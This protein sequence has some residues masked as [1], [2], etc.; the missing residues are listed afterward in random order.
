MKEEN[1]QHEVPE[2]DLDLEDDSVEEVPVSAGPPDGPRAIDL[3]DVAI[4]AVLPILP[5]RDAVAFPGTIMPLA[6][7]REKSKRL[8][9]MALAGDRL[10]CAVAQRVPEKDDPGIDD[11]HRVGTACMILKMYKLPDGTETIVVH[12][13][14]RVGIEDLTSTEPYLEARV[15]P[16]YDPEE[17]STELE[18]LMHNARHAAH[19]I[20]EL[21]P[22]VPDEARIVLDNL[23]TPGGL[24]DF[25]GANLSLS[26]VHKQEVLETLDVPSRLRKVHAAMEGQLDVLELSKKIQS[27]VRSQLDKAQREHYLR[28]QLK[29]IQHELGQE[30]GSSSEITRLREKVQAARMSKPALA[31]AER[32]IE[33]MTKIHPASPEYGVALD[34]V[35]WLCALPW[36]A[37]TK[38][39]LD[40]DRA[41]AILN[42]DHYGLAKVKPRILEFLAVRKL[43]PD[44]RGPILCFAGPPGVGKTSLGKSIA[45]ALGRKFIRM[46]LGGMRDEA[47]IR[48][49]R[50]TYI[51]AMPGRILQE[52]RKAESNNPVFML[53]EV[54]KI[55]SD[56]RGDPASALLE[57][58]DP[59]Q[60]NTFTDHYLDVP[61]DLSN[62]L[63]IATANYMDPI[64]QPLLDRME[65]IHISGYTHRE[66]LEIA[67]QYLV[68]RELEENGLKPDQ[69]VFDEAALNCL[70]TGYT[71]EA[72][73][74]NLD[75]QIAAVCR[76]RA[77]AVVRGEKGSARVTPE[78]IEADLGPPLLEPAMAAAASL[79]GVAVG[80]AY[81]PIGGDILFI[82]A[83]K[84]PGNGNLNLTGQ[85]GGVMRESAQAA[86]SIVRSRAASLGI[87]PADVLRHDYHVHVPAG[88][89]PKDGPSAG[90]AILAALVSL[91]KDRCVDRYTGITGEITLR[92]R[93]M[94][95]GGIRAKV[96]AAH[97]AGLKRVILPEGNQRDLREVPQD[98][99]E[100]LKFAF[101]QTTDD[102]LRHAFADCAGRSKPRSAI[103]RSNGAKRKATTQARG[104]KPTARRKKARRQPR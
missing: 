32:E 33:R 82:E 6:V 29:A 93:V 99:R 14:V 70:I 7:S 8:L 37:H 19:R 86:F 61:F 50:R 101:A 21:S 17:L 72:G 48:G 95:V 97:R 27:Q 102:V 76:A 79:P 81:T 3:R 13:I 94:P 59:A 49:H 66:K 26:L 60:N 77:A 87:D 91:L 5:L 4:P 68:P 83:T 44:G 1:S 46:S 84:M 35:N 42:E 52:I 31:E 73:V 58:L 98:I 55:G 85:L 65:V 20:L 47:E 103:R 12:G 69:A 2:T 11:L 80:L 74:R 53:D 67:R 18:A 43:K 96:L 15:H 51:G 57:V 71:R 16:R 89:I 9:D 78:S 100:Q 88:A 54:D 63:F 28:E 39:R 30:S 23:R 10:I 62:V 40:V 38:D 104:A 24:A 92:G 34:Y 90:S 64:P 56:F 22:N 41:E 36:R 25:L 75:R 45:R